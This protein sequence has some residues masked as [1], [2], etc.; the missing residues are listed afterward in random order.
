MERKQNGTAVSANGRSF[1]PSQERS[2]IPD[3]QL[4]RTLSTP[5]P[6]KATKREGKGNKRKEKKEKTRKFIAPYLVF[7]VEPPPS[8]LLSRRRPAVV[9]PESR[10]VF[11][12]ISCQRR[13]SRSRSSSPSSSSAATISATPGLL[14]HQLQSLLHLQLQV[15]FVR[16]GPSAPGSLSQSQTA[17]YISQS[18]GIIFFLQSSCNNF[19]S[20]IEIKSIFLNLQ[21]AFFFSV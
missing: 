18:L 20:A 5:K 4:I 15:I 11:I 6:M 9:Q 17:R 19:F 16:T 13:C 14:R 2:K 21:A 10:R 3:P 8:S 1:K 12:F 7:I